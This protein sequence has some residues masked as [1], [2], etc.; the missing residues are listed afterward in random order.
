MRVLRAASV[1]LCA[2]TLAGCLN[3]TAELVPTDTSVTG[4]L[5]EGSD[6][7]PIIF[8]LS[9]GTARID[10]ARK[11]A[12]GEMAT[13]Q[14]EYEFSTPITKIRSIRLHDYQFLM[15]GARC[16]EVEGTTQ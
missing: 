14:P 9:Y 8:G 4:N 13:V 1:G 11:G 6:C 12:R 10:E 2:L 5:V 16:V 7:V 3:I 15:F